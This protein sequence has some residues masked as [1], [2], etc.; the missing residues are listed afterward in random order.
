M[1]ADRRID[2]FRLT[3]VGPTAH[4]GSVENELRAAPSMWFAG[5]RGQIP[6]RSCPGHISGAKPSAFLQFCMTIWRA[7]PLRPD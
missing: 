3:Q 6:T 5:L 4:A 1:L 7:A 2:R